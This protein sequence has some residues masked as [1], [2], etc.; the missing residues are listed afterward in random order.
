MRQKKQRLW[1]N[2]ANS[3]RVTETVFL[4]VLDT[5]YILVVTCIE[6]VLGK[7]FCFE[8]GVV[9]TLVILQ[10]MRFE[11]SL[12][13]CGEKAILAIVH[14]GTRMFARLENVLSEILLGLALVMTQSTGEDLGNRFLYMDLFMPL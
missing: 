5:N 3:N 4:W 1:K 7:V 8:N 11:L 9:G 14:F 2:S 10:Q 6:I 13:I 12:R